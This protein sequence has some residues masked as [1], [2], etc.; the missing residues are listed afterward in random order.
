MKM[1]TYIMMLAA[2]AVLLSGCGSDKDK[3]TASADDTASPKPIIAE[4][5]APIAQLATPTAAIDAQPADAAPPPAPTPEAT[6]T[7]VVQSTP[8]VLAPVRFDYVAVSAALPALPEPVYSASGV[9]PPQDWAKLNTEQAVSQ[10]RAQ[11]AQVRVS[12]EPGKY[13]DAAKCKDMQENLQGYMRTVMTTKTDMTK[14]QHEDF[15]VNVND[16]IAEL[17]EATGPQ[18]GIALELVRQKIDRVENYLRIAE[19]CARGVE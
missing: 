12:V 8:D 19:N 2:G 17:Q 18:Y 10:A 4:Q 11:F 6:P 15:V 1:Y 14:A 5:V 9:L 7:A 13:L 3:K 16:A